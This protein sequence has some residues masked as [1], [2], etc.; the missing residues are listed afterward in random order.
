[1]GNIIEKYPYFHFSR[2]S[3]PSA[4]QLGALPYVFV[5]DEAFPLRE[6][7]MRPFPGRGANDGEKIFNY[8]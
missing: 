8:R 7:L 1:V 4:P 3:I 2:E 5:G 6:N